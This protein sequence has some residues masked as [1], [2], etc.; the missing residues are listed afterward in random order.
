MCKATLRYLRLK[1]IDFAIPNKLHLQALLRIQLRITPTIP[2]KVSAAFVPNLP[3][4]PGSLPKALSLF[5]IYSPY[6]PLGEGLPPSAE[7]L[8]VSPSPGSNASAKTPTAIPIAKKMEVIIM[9]CSRN[10]IHIFSANE[11]SLS[12]TLA[13]ISLKLVIWLVSLPFCR[14]ILSSLVL[15]SLF[16]LSLH[17]LM[18]SRRPSSY[19][20]LSRIPASLRFSCP[21]HCCNSTFFAT[22]TLSEPLM[23]LSCLSRPLSS[24][25]SNFSEDVPSNCSI[26]FLLHSLCHPP[27]LNQT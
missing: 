24:H 11:R 7:A 8:P 15:S 17:F 2:G 20:G 13:I 21:M 1:P 22:S 5:L 25:M 18:S 19:S 3:S 16:Y 4:L 10:S 27:Y 6:P 23:L 14:L 9:P 12:N 26:R